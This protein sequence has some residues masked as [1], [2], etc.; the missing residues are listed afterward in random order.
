MS[1][2]QLAPP[3]NGTVG[4]YPVV[5]L[6]R[7][8]SSRGIAL[9]SINQ[10]RF[11]EFFA[12][13]ISKLRLPRNFA[14]SAD[15]PVFVAM[16]GFSEYRTLPL[17]LRAES[18]PYCFDCW[19]ADYGRWHSFFR[20]HRIRLAFFSARQ[21]AEHFGR[22]HPAMCSVWLPEATDPNDYDGSRPL[23][24]RGIDVLELGRKN[25]RYHSIIAA[26]L[27]RNGQCHLFE[28]VKGQIIFPDRHAL[29]SGL[30]NSKISI[31]FP[32][33]Q[34]HPARSGQIETVTHRYF[35]SMASKCVIL[36]HC[37]AELRDLFG[38]NPVIEI[39]SGNETEQIDS[40][41][42]NISEY[43]YMVEQ[44]YDRLLEV[45][46]WEA[47]VQT[48]LQNVQ[49]VAGGIAVETPIARVA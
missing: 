16:M 2:R 35:E 12:K 34:T 28:H 9:V 37:P 18:V 3:E 11:A 21:A 15:G 6:A 19:P 33:S 49:Q 30:G 48:I 36:G 7:A 42:A 43:E 10:N 32:C 41:L 25:D 46:T 24:D 26:R 20:R 1:L 45:G 5:S 40:I 22:I 17:S 13:T 29:V 39:E 38:Y 44:N 47:R 4:C 27:A 14:H 8:L 31:C 23:A